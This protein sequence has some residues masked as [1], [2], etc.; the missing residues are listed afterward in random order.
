MTYDCR[1]KNLIINLEPNV[2]EL[3]KTTTLT[4][5]RKHFNL[6]KFRVFIGEYDKDFNLPSGVEP[7]YFEDT[8]SMASLTLLPESK[9]EKHIRGIIEEYVFVSE[10]SID[11]FRYPFEIKLVVKDTLNN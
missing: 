7:Q 3:G 6:P 8:D 10:D 11:T 4:V 2:I 5:T 9:G 1:K